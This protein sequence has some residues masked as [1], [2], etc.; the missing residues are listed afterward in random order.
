MPTLTLTGLLGGDLIR[1]KIAETRKLEFWYGDYTRCELTLH[2]LRFSNSPSD[3]PLLPMVAI[4]AATKNRPCPLAIVRYLVKLGG[5]TARQDNRKPYGSYGRLDAFFRYNYNESRN[6]TEREFNVRILS[7]WT[8]ADGSLR[9]QW[10]HLKTDKMKTIFH[11]WRHLVWKVKKIGKNYRWAIRE[12]NWH[13]TKWTF[14]IIV[15][16]HLS[17]L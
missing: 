2:L 3:I 1:R 15:S 13:G 12:S 10:S 4:S 5:L 6:G 17:S 9:P 16:L 7:R 11:K 8:L 14:I